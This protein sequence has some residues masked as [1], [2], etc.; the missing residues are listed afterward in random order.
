LDAVLSSILN[1]GRLYYSS[2]STPDVAT[3]NDTTLSE[4]VANSDQHTK[5]SIEAFQLLLDSQRKEIADRMQHWKLSRY[6][7]GTLPY[8][9]FLWKILNS[10]F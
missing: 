1:L 8:L 9:L 2:F 4:S 10:F 6:Q 3:S 7:I 5:K